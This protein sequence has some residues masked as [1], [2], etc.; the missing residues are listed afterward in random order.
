MR[1]PRPGELV[2]LLD[3]DGRGCVGTVERVEG[4]Y[5]CVT[6]DWSTWTGDELPSAAVQ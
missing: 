5:I 6:P 3:A 1:T 4:W 2:Y